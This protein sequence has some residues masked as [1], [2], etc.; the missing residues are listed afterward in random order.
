MTQKIAKTC[1]KNAVERFEVA[2]TEALKTWKGF[3]GCSTPGLEIK[4]LD[5]PYC[6]EYIQ[7][8]QKQ[9]HPTPEK[10]FAQKAPP[11]IASLDSEETRQQC[12]EM[13][14]NGYSLNQIKQL[15]GFGQFPT[16]RR[17]LKEEGLLKGK[18]DYSQPEKEHCI[19]LY[20]QGMTPFEI[21]SITHI[22][23]ELIRAWVSD[24]GVAR[25]LKRYS[26]SQKQLALSMYE[27]GESFAKIREV[28]GICNT[29]VKEYAQKAKVR[30][31]KKPKGGK[32]AIYSDDFQQK[33]LNLLEEGKTTSQVEEIMGVSADTV[34]KW[35]KIA[36]KTTESDI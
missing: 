18:K 31:K 25:P 19:Q 2:N 22:S 11:P 3:C 34:R 28:T 8:L 21:E 13:Y 29:M 30:R 26:E 6:L 24:A 9:I 17:W 20:S 33:C 36:Q 32:P 16:L 1:L 12:V 14:R 23:V 7:H 15:T 4:C 27:E 35:K 10:V 5:C